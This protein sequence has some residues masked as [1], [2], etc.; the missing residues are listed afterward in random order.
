M[1]TTTVMPG[2]E[3]TSDSATP[4]A[5]VE[6]GDE[7]AI[8]R[9]DEDTDIVMTTKTESRDITETMIITETAVV[10]ETLIVTE[11]TTASYADVRGNERK[12][13]IKED[14]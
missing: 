3:T 4:D 6:I 8:G 7:D 10:T 5:D 14:L 9:G 2:S 11:L 12:G 13:V 1:M